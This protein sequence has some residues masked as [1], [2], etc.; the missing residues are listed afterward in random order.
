MNQEMELLIYLLTSAEALPCEPQ[1]YGPLRLVEA[2][3]RVCR[4]LISQQPENVEYKRLA[5]CIEA[6]KGKALTEPEK[7][8]DMLREASSLL[9]DCL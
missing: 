6:G 7:F 9:V 1:S 8:F 5:S 3:S 4:I 2:A